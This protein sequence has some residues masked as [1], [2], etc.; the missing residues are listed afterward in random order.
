MSPEVSS[1]K[2][3]DAATRSAASA[4]LPERRLALV[5]NPNVGKSVLFGLLTG[6]SLLC[7]STFF[8]LP[9]FMLGALW[10]FLNRFFNF[11]RILVSRYF[12]RAI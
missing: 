10:L 11:V 1:S 5:G 3:P 2:A 4:A 7:R 8:L 6:V 9:P 12:R